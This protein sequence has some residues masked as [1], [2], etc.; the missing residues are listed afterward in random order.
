[1]L[2]TGFTGEYEHNLDDKS[3]VSLP[4]KIKKY[5]E[6]IAE[7][8]ETAGRV[9]L[10][11]SATRK[12]LELFT[13]DDWQR[14][15]ASYNQGMSLKEN[16][17]EDSIVDVGR[18]TDTV[19]MD[20]AGRIMINSKLKEFAEIKK[21]VVFVGAIDRVLIWGAEKLEEYDKGR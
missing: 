19:T 8:E 4:S 1:V 5:I 15:V 17:V 18:R 21:Q 20:K 10:T 13:L 3:R 14:M 16:K 6:G 11:K 9:V 7:S 2:K 12:C